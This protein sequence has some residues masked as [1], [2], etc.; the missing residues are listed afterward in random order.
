MALSASTENMA[1]RMFASIG[2]P[3]LADDPRF[4]TNS[5]RLKHADEFDALIGPIIAQRT[6]GE[7][8]AFFEKAEVT[9]G[10]VY[11]ISQI[12]ED[13]HVIERE[14][15]TE[16]PDPEMDFLPMH[17]PGAR[18]FRTPASI[19]TPA[20]GLGEHNRELLSEVGVG[21]AAYGELLASGIAVEGQPQKQPV[22]GGESRRAVQE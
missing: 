16:Y 21:D 4:R 19:R 11:D 7:N 15:L 14:L 6:Q 2:R 1:R 5:D 8:V 22:N 12:M 20:P 3:E 9:I 13:P 10:P 18:F 17:H